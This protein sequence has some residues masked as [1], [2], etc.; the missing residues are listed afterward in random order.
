MRHQRNIAVSFSDPAGF[1]AAVE[2][3]PGLNEAAAR[4][5]IRTE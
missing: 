4:V 2:A 1:V 5:H 3:H